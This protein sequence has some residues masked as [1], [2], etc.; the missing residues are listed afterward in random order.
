MAKKKKEE[1]KVD[2]EVG[3]LKVKEKPE[4]QPIT[5]D[6]EGINDNVLRI[7]QKIDVLLRNFGDNE[8]ALEQRKEYVDA[9]ADKKVK[10]MSEVILPLLNSLL[11]TKDQEYIH[12]PNRGEIISEQVTKVNSI[13]DGSYFTEGD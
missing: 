4:V 6:V 5:E 8:E 2:N 13:I 3:S 10:A 7:E 12:W 9:L 1:P 11:R